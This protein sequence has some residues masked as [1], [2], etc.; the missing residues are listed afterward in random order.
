M[1]NSYTVQTIEGCRL[2]FGSVPL[3]EMSLLLTGFSKNAVM[4]C[5]IADKIGATLVVGEPDQLE[6]LRKMDLPI[7]DKRCSEAAIATKANLPNVANWLMNGERGLSSNAL[8]KH[9]FHLDINAGREHPRDPDDLRRCF[10]FIKSTNS[11]D[12][13][14]LME[15]ISPDWASLVKYWSALEKMYNLEKSKGLHKAPKTYEL[16][17]T[18]FNKAQSNV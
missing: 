13:L 3:M 9:L 14:H 15:S 8:C 12:K 17:K 4:A 5:D 11:R 18:A 1:N 10:E 16:M 7:S 6:V 2:V